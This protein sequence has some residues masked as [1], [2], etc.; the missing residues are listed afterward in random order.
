MPPRRG[1]VTSLESYLEDLNPFLKGF[2]LFY[3]KRLLV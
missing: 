3:F 2:I 1:K